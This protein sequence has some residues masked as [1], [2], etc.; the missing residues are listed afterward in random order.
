MRVAASVRTCRGK[1]EQRSPHI[2]RTFVVNNVV[3]LRLDC[4]L[5]EGMRV[6]HVDHPDTRKYARRT[7]LAAHVFFNES[8]MRAL[9]LKK[10]VFFDAPITGARLRHVAS[11]LLTF[12]Q[13]QASRTMLFTSSRRMARFFFEPLVTSSGSD[14]C[15]SNSAVANKRRFTGKGLRLS[16]YE[17]KG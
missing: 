1:T 13:P 12:S 14:R 9:L 7:R 11:H 10:V 16:V 2:I 8:R 3:I 5:P 4:R 6:S 15:L 17:T